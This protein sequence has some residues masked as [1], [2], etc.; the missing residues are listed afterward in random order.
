LRSWDAFEQELRSRVTIS[1]R[2]TMGFHLHQVEGDSASFRDQNYYGQGGQR[3]TDYTDLSIR[4]DR[5]FGLL[6]FDWRWSSSRYRS[7]FDTNRAVKVHKLLRMQ[8]PPTPCLKGVGFLR[9][10]L[11]AALPS[12]AFLPSCERDARAPSTRDAGN[13]G[14]PPAMPTAREKT[15]PFEPCQGGRRSG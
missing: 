11:P 1:G 10:C 5:L 14:V 12:R 2:K 9:A 15:Y 4:V 7:P 3:T 8:N 13:A 6:S